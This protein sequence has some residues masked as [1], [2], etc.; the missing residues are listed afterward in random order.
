[1]NLGNHS[2]TDIL[3]LNPHKHYWENLKSNNY[4]TWQLSMVLD[5]KELDLSGKAYV[6]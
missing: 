6:W 4:K 5:P 1:M 2:P 3:E